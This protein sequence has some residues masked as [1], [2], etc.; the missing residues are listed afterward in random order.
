MMLLRLPSSMQMPSNVDLPWSSFPSSSSVLFSLL[1][2]LVLLAA[3][4]TVVLFLRSQLSSERQKKLP[5]TQEHGQQQPQQK[6]ES[7]AHTRSSWG[8]KLL[9][10]GSVPTLPISLRMPVSEV[11]SQAVGLGV[12]VMSNN[13]SKRPGERQTWQQ[14]RRGPAFEQPLPALYQTEPASM[15]KM[16]MSRHTFRK[17][18]QRPP[19]RQST[20]TPQI[21]ISR[22]P[23]SMV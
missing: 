9:T 22:R 6:V 8:W 15:A 1:A 11:K 23:P 5:L 18:T 7:G 13:A 14:P 19:P 16:I 4:R 21:Q 10:W 12:G 17:P 2:S 3:I 20:P